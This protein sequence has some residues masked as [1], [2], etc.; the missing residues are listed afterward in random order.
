VRTDW[1]ENEEDVNDTGFELH[2]QKVRP[3]Y[4]TSMTVF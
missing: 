2:M 3:E 4:E 1:F